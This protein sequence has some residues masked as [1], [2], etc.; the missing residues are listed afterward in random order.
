MKR[1]YGVILTSFNINNHK[2]RK[3]SVGELQPGK[4]VSKSQDWD[5][6]NAR[7]SESFI[8]HAV[9]ILLFFVLA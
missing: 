1:V 5:R 9:C 7:I 2:R 6:V 3:S 8:F 4:N